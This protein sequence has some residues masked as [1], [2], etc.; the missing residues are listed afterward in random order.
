[1][2][3]VT[4]AQSLD[5]FA[6][7][8]ALTAKQA[9]SSIPK[10]SGS[11]F[12]SGGVEL[13]LGAI[14]VGAEGS[15]RATSNGSGLRPVYYDAN[16]LF[17]PFHISRSIVPELMLGLGSQNVEGFEALGSCG[18]LSNCA[19]YAGNHLAAHVGL[20]VKVYVTEHIF[21]RPEAHFYFI[22]N[23]TAFPNAQRWGVSLGYTFGS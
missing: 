13:W 6:G 21:L 5:I 12:P 22:H 14:G 23:N 4:R 17:A 9:V 19:Q 3:P 10:L 16:V 1:M 18:G 15:F 11:V 2:A 8:N 20:A 7:L